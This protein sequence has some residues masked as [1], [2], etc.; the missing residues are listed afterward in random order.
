MTTKKVER[1]LAAILSADVVGYAKLMGADEESTLARLQAHRKQFIDPTIAEHRGRIVK[2][3]G[4]GALVE[5][6]SAVDAV[7]CAIE[8]QRGMAERNVAVPEDRRIKFRIGINLGDVMIEGDDLYGDGV[9]VAARIEGLAEPSGICISNTVFDQVRDRIPH[10]FEDL[11][12]HSVKNITRPVRVY[13]V[14]LSEREA[15]MA[16]PELPHQAGAPELPDRPSIAVLPFDNMSGDPEQEYFTDGIAEDIITALSLWRWFP[17]IARN[18]TFTYKGKAVDIKQ[19][20][21]ELGVRYV[22]EGSVRKAGN[23]V[24]I[25]AQ[26]IDA[27][28]GAHVWAEKFDRELSD[29]FDLQD[30]ITRRVAGTLIPELSAAEQRRVFRE[31]PRDLN[32]W[33]LFLRGQWHF[34]RFNRDDMV[35]ARRL[36][37]AALDLDPN[38]PSAHA[39]VAQTYLWSVLLDWEDAPQEALQS[40]HLHVTRALASDDR[41]PMAHAAMGGMMFLLRRYNEA[42]AELNVAV[43]LN[44]SLAVSYVVL[45]GVRLLNGEPAEAIT[46]CGQAMRLSP[47]DPLAFWP[48]TIVGL[49]NYLLKQYEEASIWARN[50]LRHKPD[51]PFPNFNLAAACA[52]L[53]R[54]DESK[55]ALA[56]AYRVQADH[57]F[58][59]IQAGYPFK[60]PA[61]F[62]HVIDG[63]R[64]AGWEG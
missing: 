62:D 53:G 26:L 63:L 27:A 54:L 40:A 7:K 37:R 61:D 16:R 15:A 5:F 19:V 2:L 57:S 32:A 21:R 56:Q 10:D 30:E 3:M 22:L 8:I 58:S 28:T 24:R 11:G 45:A 13:R 4:D 34:N 33:D 47:H 29:I 35:E 48:E 6:A 51:F 44:P 9:N 46:V 55:E 20:G 1:R 17:V 42:V 23:R 60:N 41:D 18:S 25:S 39:F 52:Q 31:P 43:S 49:S 36:Y 14:P 50:A 38:F 12:E 59:F 64:K